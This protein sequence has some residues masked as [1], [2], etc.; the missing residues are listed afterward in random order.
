[1]AHV[2]MKKQFGLGPRD[3]AYALTGDQMLF[4]TNLMIALVECKAI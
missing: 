2:V 4:R 3:E 1:V